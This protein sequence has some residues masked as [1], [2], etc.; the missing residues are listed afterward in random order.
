[1]GS[2]PLAFNIEYTRYYIN[3]IG[4]TV[5]TNADFAMYIDTG[6]LALPIR[7][8]GGFLSLRG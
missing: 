5:E 8:Y 4:S 1:M 7:L 3:G 6:Y 2:G